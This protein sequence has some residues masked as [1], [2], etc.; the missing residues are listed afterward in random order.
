MKKTS[1]LFRGP[2]M[3]IACVTLGFIGLSTAV[4]ADDI[5][6]DSDEATDGGSSDNTAN[7]NWGT[8]AF[9]SPD[10]AGSSATTA[11]WI[12]ANTAVF[13]AGS[14][15]TGSSTVTLN[16]NTAADGL[17]FEEGAISLV[18]A[19]TAKTLSL[20]AGGITISN[21][22]P[23]SGIPTLG[24][25]TAATSL[26]LSLT[27]NQIWTNNI[28]S[29]ALI[30]SGATSTTNANLTLQ[31]NFDFRASGSVTPAISLGTGILTQ[32]GGT[33]EYGSGTGTNGGFFQKSGQ[34]LVRSTGAFGSGTITLGDSTGTPSA[35]FRATSVTIANALVLGSNGTIV[36]NNLGTGATPVFTGGITGTNK[37]T[38]Q[39]VIGGAGTSNTTFNSASSS[40][41]NHNG[42]LLLQNAGNATAAGAIGILNINTGVGSNV[43]NVTVSN[44]TSADVGITKGAQTVVFGSTAKSYTGTTSINAGAV[45]EIAASNLIPDAS[46][47]ALNGTF[48]LR[49]FNETLGA[50]NGDGTVTKTTGTSTLTLGSGDGSGTF[51]GSLGNGSGTLNLTKVGSGTQTL[52]AASSYSGTT[53]IGNGGGVLAITHGSALG[54]GPVAITRGGLN[55][56]SL[57]LSN[58]ITVANNFNFA[59][60][61]SFG[62]GGTGQIVN[63]SGSNTLTG[64]LTLTTTGGN[65]I[66]LASLAG[67]LTV[68]NTVTSTIADNTRQLG[69]SGPGDGLISGDIVN[70]GSN[71]LTLWKSDSGTWTLTGNNTYTGD[72]NVSGGTLVIS[73]NARLPD[74]AAARLTGTGK[75]ILDFT[76]TDY[77]S[78]FFIDGVAQTAN[79][80]TY[81]GTGSGA[82]VIDN[83]H[84]S[85]TGKIQVG[86]ATDP[87]TA[88][89]NSF[90]F[91]PGD[92]KS[93]T[94]DPDGDG[95]NNLLEFALDGDPSSSTP[96]GK[97]VSKIDSNHLTLTLPV[98]TGATFTGTGPLLSAAISNVIYHIDGSD[99][100]TGFI[101]GDEEITA[102]SED[103]P[104]LSTGWSYRTFRLTSTVGS[105]P[106]GFLRAGVSE[107]P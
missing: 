34:A 67:L 7:G 50:L 56:G 25:T 2:S 10:A 95:M 4:Y 84:F 65:G 45:L 29:A 107:A 80:T 82:N 97:V 87:F 96:S 91:D 62:G 33:I 14:D 23:A 43:T 24:G 5:Y 64:T 71:K 79:G 40:S 21:G 48:N 27:A 105:A 92:D 106:K 102:L 85:G 20:G 17:R 6:W 73:G 59:S 3:R 44:A 46:N 101:S 66:N 36:I 74:T 61:N 77:V 60:A 19:T 31:G 53:T 99:D 47:V 76:G 12:P 39:S 81:G 11:T 86:V 1:H 63:V 52:T 104:T 41:I 94:G 42:E 49:S 100:L 8:S 57:E 22:T 103:L 54:T 93:K 30:R 70:T 83:V 13:S 89:I 28:S 55:T 98:R 18:S 72:T 58:N 78:A 15:V 9:W 16:A 26:V 38:L 37:V 88:W 69:L 75:L 90:T 35:T 32:T 68:T 51:G